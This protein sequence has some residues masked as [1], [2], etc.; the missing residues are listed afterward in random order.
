MVMVMTSA[1]SLFET[2]SW[3]CLSQAVRIWAYCLTSLFFSF[4]ICKRGMIKHLLY[5]VLWE[6]NIIYKALKGMFG[7]WLVQ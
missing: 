7:M 3:L 1:T 5:R 4:L 6:L 2:E